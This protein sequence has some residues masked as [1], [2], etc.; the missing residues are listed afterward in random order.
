MDEDSVMSCSGIDLS[1]S[2]LRR[3]LAEDDEERE[4]ALRDRF[5]REDDALPQLPATFYGILF[6]QLH[7]SGTLFFFSFHDVQ[8]NGWIYDK[9]C[10]VFL[11]QGMVLRSD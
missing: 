8:E 2:F 10:P 3:K 5:I 6:S 4:E 1:I 7:E 11:N 9:K